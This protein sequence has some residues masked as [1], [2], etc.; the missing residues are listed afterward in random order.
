MLRM[1]RS[2]SGPVL[3]VMAGLGLELSAG[4]AVVIWPD[5]WVAKVVLALGAV[6]LIGSIC[7]WFFTNYRLRWPVIARARNAQQSTI[8]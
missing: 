3:W 6:L 5:L 2:V 8:G 1:L 4:A 7:A